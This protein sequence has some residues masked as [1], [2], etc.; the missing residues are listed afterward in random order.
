MPDTSSSKLFSN[1]HSH[2]FTANHAPD[3]FLKTAIHNT[4]FAKLVDKMVQKQGTRTV[5]KGG[6]WIFGLFSHNYRNTVKRYIEFVE[7]G[8]SATQEDIF[9][10]EAQ[11]YTRMGDYRIVVLTQVLDYLDY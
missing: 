6:H 11:A 2:I 5:L 7:I 8:T 9:N 4:F 3:F 10:K 1:A